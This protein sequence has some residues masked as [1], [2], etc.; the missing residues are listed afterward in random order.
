MSACERADVDHLTGIFDG[1]RATMVGDSRERDFST[2]VFY[3]QPTPP[4][5]QL[6][7]IMRSPAKLS[8]VQLGFGK[9]TVTM[10]QF[11]IVYAQEI[12]RISF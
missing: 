1:F 11:Y 8:H 4:R 9:V 5:P 2:H 7:N 12:E 10:F 3:R 6:H